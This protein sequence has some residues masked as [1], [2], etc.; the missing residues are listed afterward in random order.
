MSSAL[1]T[2]WYGPV[3]VV[4]T[5][6]ERGEQRLIRRIEDERDDDHQR[7]ARDRQRDQQARGDDRHHQRRV[8]GRQPENGV[9]ERDHG[10]R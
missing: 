8:L 3:S 10:S 4:S 5:V 9:G 2:L 7:D 6:G 1:S